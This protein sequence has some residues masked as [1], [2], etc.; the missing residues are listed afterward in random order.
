MIHKDQVLLK[1]GDGQ[2]LYFS[3]PVQVIQV[4]QADQ[5]CAALRQ[6][7]QR[8]ENDGY[9]AAGFV[10]YEAAPAFDA[11]MSVHPAPD[12]PLIWFGIYPPPRILSSAQVFADQQDFSVAQP[13]F[14]SQTTRKLYTAAIHKIKDYIA[15][16]LTY[17][18]NYT[19][20]L[21]WHFEGN[22]WSFFQ[23]LAQSQN[24]YAACIDTGRYVICSASPELF[25]KRSGD[26]IYSRP[27]KGTLKRGRTTREDAQQA[28]W[29]RNSLKNRAENV[30]IVDMIRN[31]LGRIARTGTVQV[32]ELFAVETYPTLFQMTSTVQAQTHATLQ[33]V[34][35]AL[36]PCASI[37]GAPKISTMRIIAELEPSPRRIYTGSIGYLAPGRRAQFNIAIRTALIDRQTATAEYGVGGGVVW[38]STSAGEYSEALLKARVLTMPQRP[39]MLLESL[40]WDSA[41]GF[42]LPEKHLARMQDSAAYF[43]FPFS[44]AEWHSRL[45]QGVAGASAPQKVRI[46]L[47]RFGNLQVESA[48]LASLKKPFLA[49]LSASPINDQDPFLFHKTT[50]REIYPAI[51]DGVNDLILWNTAGQLTE[52]T[53]GNLVV[54]LGGKYYTPPLSCGLLPGVFRAHLLESGAIM[55]RIIHREDLPHCSRV[56]LVN[57]VRKW[58]EVTLAPPL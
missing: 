44:S 49:R 4:D 30:M 47:D 19:M 29:L 14:Q 35:S 11:A 16:G 54:E 10:S 41:G 13:D 37:T 46:L 55:E 23:N 43:D 1:N 51:P 17:Q 6:V 38:D 3:D 26:N 50:R 25:F 52:F 18:V 36:F 24:K 28:Q 48:P 9:H 39:F 57:S 58:I 2:W 53:I 22:P 40:L 42:F 31:D 27:M 8:V 32:P 5:V 7:E 45:A 12:F 56:F 34:F 21:N 33:Q 20:R 15:Q